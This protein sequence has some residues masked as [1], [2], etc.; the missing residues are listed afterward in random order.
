MITICAKFNRNLRCR[1]L[2][3]DFFGRSVVECPTYYSYDDSKL[4][5]YLPVSRIDT[6]WR[7]QGTFRDVPPKD[8]QTGASLPPPPKGQTV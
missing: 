3:R 8:P 6:H 5:K 2:F 4:N 7:I 1:V